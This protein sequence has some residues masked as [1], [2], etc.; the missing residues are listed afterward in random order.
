M[1]VFHFSA[2]IDM[3]LAHR[4]DFFDLI[5]FLLRFRH[6]LRDFRC[7]C[8]RFFNG[9]CGLCLASILSLGLVFVLVFEIAEICAVTPRRY[10]SVVFEMQLADRDFVFVNRCQIDVTFL[11]FIVFFTLL[12]LGIVFFGDF[13]RFFVFRQFDFAFCLCSCNERHV[14]FKRRH[15]VDCV[16]S[17]VDFVVAFGSLQAVFF[18]LFD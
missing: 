7:F 5:R 3:H 17:V 9:L 15:R 14:A 12:R 16:E 8:R 11:L 4:L 6:F 18:H 13:G 10:A 1:S 2:E